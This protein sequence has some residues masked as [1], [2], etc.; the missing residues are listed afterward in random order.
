MGKA[1]SA[2]MLRLLVFL[3]TL[4]VHALRPIFRRREVFLIENLAL[5]QQVI[6]LKKKRP[7]PVPSRPART[8]LHQLLS[9][10]LF[11]PG[12]GQGH[13][14]QTPRYVAT[15][16]YSKGCGVASGGQIAPSLRMA[17]GS[18]NQLLSVDHLQTENDE[19]QVLF[20]TA[21]TVS[22]EVSH[23][24]ACTFIPELEAPERDWRNRGLVA[25]DPWISGENRVRD[26][27]RTH[28]SEISL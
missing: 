15:I 26:G 9:R 5:R 27:F 8:L 24:R 14:T 7:R 21:H 1:N 12:A 22:I 3:L 18:L 10:G 4:G 13:A 25:L 19:G 16:M 17:R 6:A 2:A 11:P 20:R 23:T 28:K